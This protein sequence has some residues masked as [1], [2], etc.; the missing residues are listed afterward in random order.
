LRKTAEGNQAA[1][2]KPGEADERKSMKINLLAF[3]F[4]VIASVFF[5]CACGFGEPRFMNQFIGFSIV[6]AVAA[7]LSTKEK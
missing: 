5:F 7:I 6:A 2:K 3:L 4:W 1:E